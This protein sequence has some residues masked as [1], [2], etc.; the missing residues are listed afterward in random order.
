MRYPNPNL[1]KIHRNYTVDEVARLC[2]KHKNTVR[3]WIKQGLPICD[4]KRPVLILGRDLAAFLKKCRARNKQT[5]KPEELY[6]VK[7]RAPQKPAAG[8]VEYQP[9]TATVGN[10]IAICP[11]CASIM[12]RR[13]SM[14]KLTQ[15]Q[16]EMGIT[17]PQALEHIAE[18]NQPT[19]NSDLK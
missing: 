18:S 12:N 8:M 13:I 9:I 16:A 17:F 3:A 5:C 2:G 15:F 4:D 6:C 10:L 19:V 11:T 1:V 14:A 7:C